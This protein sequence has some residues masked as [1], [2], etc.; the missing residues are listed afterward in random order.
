MT[1][2]NT[3]WI[4]TDTEVIEEKVEVEGRRSGEDIGGGFGPP[5]RVYESE[6]TVQ[7]HRVPIPADKVK[8]QMQ[9]MVTIVNDLFDQAST[10]T[11]LQ[12][13]EVE[14][15]VDISAE[16]KVSL[17]GSGGKLGSKGGIKLKFVRP[18]A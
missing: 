15:S 11:G 4:V 2:D 12:L 13:N 3:L 6:K 16:G 9:S 1:D 8:A 5:R 10:R 7:R 14:L 18:P 17:I